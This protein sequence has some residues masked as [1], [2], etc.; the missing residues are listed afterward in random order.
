MAASASIGMSA[1]ASSSTATRSGAS[2]PRDYRLDFF[3]GLSLFF[4]FIDHI[5]A[6]PVSYF[7]L[8]SFALNDAA[9]VFIFISGYTAAMVY[10]R[11]VGR[12][13]IL[14][15]TARIYRRVWTLYVAHLCMFMIYMA[16]IAYT[17]RH[18]NNPLFI[19]DLGVGDFITRPDET[20][21]KVLLLQY[22]P[23]FLDILPLYMALLAIFPLLLLALRRHVLLALVPS[24]LIYAAAQIWQINMP[25]NEGEGWYFNPFAW[26]LLFTI[27]AAFGYASGQG[28]D[29]LPSGRWL[30]VL[31][32]L[33]AAAGMLIQL[34]WTSHDLLGMG[35]QILRR[36]LWPVDKTSLPLVRI[37]NVLALAVL[38]ARLVPR[39]AGFLTRPA[40]WLVVLCGQHSLEV[41]ALSI[42]LAVL[43]NI[44]LTLAGR[45]L[46]LHLVI[47][48]CGMLIM[49]GL[50]LLMSW[51]A[52]GGRL[53]ARP[54]ALAVAR[55]DGAGGA[56]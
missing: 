48:A 11:A 27:A 49:I 19:E 30:V 41:F 18:F 37:G 33:I 7:T 22:Q 38:V 26:Q 43:G 40:G 5:P 54:V 4:I 1:S 47:T 52:G 3:R 29:M 14:L 12:D 28:R 42:L 24:M 51:F 20:I 16:E 39:N 35:P 6:N 17:A 55:T 46:G 50:A 36:T 34:S 9:E 56:P 21:V 31:A 32:A 23:T 15:T 45:S 25:G 8:K 44:V 10:G 2:Q 53:P 13:G